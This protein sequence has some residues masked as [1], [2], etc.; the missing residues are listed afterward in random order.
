[1]QGKAS[2]AIPEGKM[3]VLREQGYVGKDIIL[4]IRPED[5]HDEPVFIEASKGATIKA[6]VDVSE[7]TG[8]ETMVYSTFEG[9][10]FVARI[11][12][13]TDINPGEILELAFDMN[14]VHFFDTETESRIR[15]AE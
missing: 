4:G 8:A 11:D 6:H 10:D 13:R 2:I 14:K 12:S 15:P 9:Q 1:M 5:L 3:K 7:L